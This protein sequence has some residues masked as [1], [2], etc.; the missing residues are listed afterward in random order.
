M[1]WVLA[2]AVVL[3]LVLCVALR[4]RLRA[5]RSD[6]ETAHSRA[7]IRRQ[8]AARAESDRRRERRYRIKGTVGAVTVLGRETG[9]PCRIINVSRSGM[10]IA[11]CEPL[12]G[13]VQVNV[14]WEDKFFVGSI[15]YSFVEGEEHILG[16]GLISSNSSP[17]GRLAGLAYC[18]KRLFMARSA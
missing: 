9:V 12:P 2:G 6:E 8:E 10:R 3:I 11:A 4:S 13:E 17:A 18:F 15:R 7:L 5:P 16:L 1:F 14:T